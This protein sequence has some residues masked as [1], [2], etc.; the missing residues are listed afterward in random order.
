[1][2]SVWCYIPNTK[3]IAKQIQTIIFSAIPIKI[4]KIFEENLFFKSY[5]SLLTSNGQSWAWLNM[6]QSMENLPVCNCKFHRFHPNN[7]FEKW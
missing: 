6:P 7:F 4:Q 5:T 2:I 3:Q 1:M